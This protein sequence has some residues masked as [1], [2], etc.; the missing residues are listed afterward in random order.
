MSLLLPLSLIALSVWI[1]LLAFRGGFWLA[2]ERDD[3]GMSADALVGS[4]S[5]TV[6]V[7]ARDEAD[8]IARSV[9]S[10]LAQDY[11]GEFRII[12]VDDQSSDGT[13]EIARALEC[14]GRLTVL[15]GE[16]KQSAW[17]G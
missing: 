16:E 9:G 13:A 4:P 14:D 11:S 7:P 2:R 3:R 15:Q 5:V 17:T 8:H 12:V 10:L 1:Y 6:I